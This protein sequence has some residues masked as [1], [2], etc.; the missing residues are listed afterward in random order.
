VPAEV[1]SDVPWDGALECCVLKKRF[2]ADGRLAVALCDYI[3]WSELRST[4][5][6]QPIE[7]SLFE[8]SRRRCHRTI[9]NAVA[10]IMPMVVRGNDSTELD[11]ASG[12]P[13]IRLRETHFDDRGDPV[14]LSSIDLDDRVLRLEVFRAQ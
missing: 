2:V 3:P 14:A 9:V 10:Q 11:L 4:A 7:A 6:R 1:S 12:E 13:F 8:F 5:L